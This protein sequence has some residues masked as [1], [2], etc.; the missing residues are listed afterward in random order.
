[1]MSGYDEQE[2]MN[3]FAGKGVASFV[4][5]P[6]RIADLAQAVHDAVTRK[7]GETHH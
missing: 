7:K 4:S 6:F 1:M 2:V 5:K 3:G